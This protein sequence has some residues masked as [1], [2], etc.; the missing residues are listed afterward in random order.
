MDYQLVPYQSS[1]PV[2]EEHSGMPPQ[3]HAIAY[4]PTP[5]SFDFYNQR[6]SLLAVSTRLGIQ[7]WEAVFESSSLGWTKK[8]EAYCPGV[9]HMEWMPNK[10]GLA[11]GDERGLITLLQYNKEQGCFKSK[12]IHDKP[13]RGETTS[14]SWSGNSSYLASSFH[15]R[16][17]EDETSNSMIIIHKRASASRTNEVQSIEMEGRPNLIAK[18]HPVH[19]CLFI[20]KRRW[21]LDIKIF[22]NTITG[23]E[24]ESDKWVQVASLV[25]NI[26]SF[27]KYD[28]YSGS[29]WTP[30]AKQRVSFQ[31]KV[32]TGNRFKKI[33]SMG[34]Y[35]DS[36]I[37]IGY[38]DG[39]I[40]IFT[41][42][43]GKYVSALNK[44]WEH[45]WSKAKCW[46][47]TIP[48]LS[49]QYNTEKTPKVLAVG[50][51]HGFVLFYDFIEA[52][53]YTEI[54]N[55]DYEWETNYYKCP[56][57]P[58]EEVEEEEEEEPTHDVTQEFNSQEEVEPVKETKFAICQ[59]I[60]CSRTVNME[61]IKAIGFKM[62][63]TLINYK[64]TF[65]NLAYVE[66]KKRLVNGKYPEKILEWNYNS[67]HMI[68]GLI[69]DKKKGNIIKVDHYNNVKMSYHG[70]NEMPYEESK[71]VYGSTFMF[72][73]PEFAAMDTTFSCCEGY[74]FAQLV[75]LMDTN[76]QE[77]P[78]P[79]YM[80]L[81]KH[82]REAF[83]QG[84][85]DGTLKQSV[86]NDLARYI[87]KDPSLLPMLQNI[88]NKGISTFL[89]TDSLWDYTDIVMDYALHQD[90]VN[91]HS[92]LQYF[93]IV[94]TGS[95]SF[96]SEESHVEL[97]DV[98]IE[99][100][101][102]SNPKEY[103]LGRSKTNQAPKEIQKVYQ[104]D[105]NLM[106]LMPCTVN[107]H[108]TQTPHNSPT[109][110]HSYR[111]TPPRA[112]YMHAKPPPV[113]SKDEKCLVWIVEGWN[114]RFRLGGDVGHLQ[115][116]LPNTNDPKQ[117]LYVTHHITKEMLNNKAQGWKTMQIIPELEKEL[118]IIREQ[119]SIRQTFSPTEW[120][121]ICLHA[122]M[123]KGDSDVT[124]EKKGMDSERETAEKR[125]ASKFNDK[126]G[127][128]MKA[129]NKNSRFAREVERSAWLY[130][131]RASNLA[132]ERC[133]EQSDQ[134]MA[135]DSDLL[136]FHL[137][138]D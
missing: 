54:P 3:I 123:I 105:C 51:E 89:I 8:F 7:I 41:K 82:L 101:K 20:A 4:C 102:I 28:H 91:K 53:P 97:F 73:E 52:G 17:T 134:L 45:H 2:G 83:D 67:E 93:D 107:V 128:V 14:I 77:V 15:P 63:Y 136:S 116:L 100:G 61:D 85:K 39:S 90:K 35:I 95:R 56:S 99:T 126:W 64:V 58:D 50:G 129:G 98:E 115:R 40:E 37:A 26:I 24:K 5:M 38:T 114:D 108:M 65:E 36:T 78:A 106:P 74:L 103:Q 9:K 43:R 80:T 10:L 81:Y 25:D 30:T 92:W 70:M 79:T 18:F 34:C 31:Y 138:K 59:Q 112:V 121:S 125:L 137:G 75:D 130:T 86:A 110:T 117:V 49:W 109:H 72:E 71:N 120:F 68:R 122:T 132:A 66:A 13:S 44:Y 19:N 12:I 96:F 118:Q 76:P 32:N 131:S 113:K 88:K 46:A 47:S 29:E 124:S 60:F 1:L 27:Y 84:Y 94:F 135:H 119:G 111:V 69:I 22:S 104:I 133:Y 11:Y 62:E 57:E 6:R 87:D 33:L 55:R 48:C 23:F 127:P 21:G 42:K 16:A